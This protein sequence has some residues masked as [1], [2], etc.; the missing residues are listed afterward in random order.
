MFN[1]IPHTLFTAHLGAFDVWEFPPNS[2]AIDM[3]NSTK[4]KKNIPVYVAALA[5]LDVQAKI[6]EWTLL[7]P[8][9]MPTDSSLY[10]LLAELKAAIDQYTP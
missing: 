3:K 4:K 8:G 6:S 7:N 2:A 5:A 9:K 1:Q 10:L